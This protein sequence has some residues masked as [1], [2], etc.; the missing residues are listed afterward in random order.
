MASSVD[1]YQ[2]FKEEIVPIMFIIFSGKKRGSDMSLFMLSW[3][4]KPETNSLRKKLQYSQEET[5]FC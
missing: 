2:I 1:S 3:C 5:I 4:P